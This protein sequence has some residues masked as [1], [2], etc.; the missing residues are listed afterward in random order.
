MHKG[1]RISFRKT[2]QL[3]RRF[4]I[5]NRCIQEKYFPYFFDFERGEEIYRIISAKSR[6]KNKKVLD[7]GAGIGTLSVFFA[8][9]RAKVTAIEP[10]KI[11][12]LLMKN[13]A[14]ENK[15]KL[16]II[17]EDFLKYRFGSKE[18]Y[19]I[20]ICSDVI[21]HIE[22]KIEFVRKMNSIL[23]INGYVVLK[24]PNRYSIIENIC[25]SHFNLPFF[26]FSKYLTHKV[27]KKMYTEKI[28]SLYLSNKS[29]ITNIFNILGFEVKDLTYQYFMRRNISPNVLCNSPFRR[30]GLKVWGYIRKNNFL[31]KIFINQAPQ[32]F[33]LAKKINNVN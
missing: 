9:K 27:A 24:T 10:N 14:K 28:K 7:L 15:I 29:E 2:E 11:A 31:S 1:T 5:M 4:S 21:E 23:K 25:D 26:A 18:R 32:L 30:Y 16:K 12:T 13:L 3:T 19:D 8:K 6:I 20:I 22:D 33:I 17:A